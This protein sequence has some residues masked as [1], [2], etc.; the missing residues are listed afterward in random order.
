MKVQSKSIAPI[1]MSNFRSRKN[2]T[3]FINGVSEYLTGSVHV[4]QIVSQRGT[5]GKLFFVPTKAEM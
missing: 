3:Y 5:P 2:E 1:K 4:D